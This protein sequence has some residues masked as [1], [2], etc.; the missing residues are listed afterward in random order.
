MNNRIRT[1]PSK[2]DISE[3]KEAVKSAGASE[4]TQIEKKTETAIH[5][6]NL[7]AFAKEHPKVE[8]TPFPERKP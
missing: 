8:V 3:K 1:D 5:E 6:K 7:E 2:S 4:T